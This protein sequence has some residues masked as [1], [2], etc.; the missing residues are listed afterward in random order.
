M[1]TL[2][3]SEYSLDP[4]EHITDKEITRCQSA[5]ILSRI[6]DKLHIYL[7]DRFRFEVRDRITDRIADTQANIKRA[8]FGLLHTPYSTL[9]IN[10]GHK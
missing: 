1:R 4:V 3:A 9:A 10:Q 5:C 7:S 8:S 6:R 2:P